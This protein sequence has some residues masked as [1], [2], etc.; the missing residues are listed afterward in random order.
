MQD[1]FIENVFDDIESNATCVQRIRSKFS[2]SLLKETVA[3]EAKE[4]K[5][6]ADSVIQS[7]RAKYNNLNSFIERSEYFKN[8]LSHMEAAYKKILKELNQ[9]PKPYELWVDSHVY[10]LMKSN[11]FRN[12]V[13]YSMSTGLIYENK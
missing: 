3:K 7:Y 4:L 1:T 8:T 13:V 6:S 9:Q 12:T 5:Q 10:Q 11:G 2:D